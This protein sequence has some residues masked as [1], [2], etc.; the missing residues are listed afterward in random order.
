MSTVLTQ[1]SAVALAVNVGDVIVRPPFSFTA[2]PSNVLNQLKLRIVDPESG[3]DNFG[4]IDH[5]CGVMEFRKHCS[6]TIVELLKELRT[7]VM[8]RRKLARR[9]A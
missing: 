2:A 5:E 9:I 6:E 7:K 3:I 4:Y 8:V 1:K